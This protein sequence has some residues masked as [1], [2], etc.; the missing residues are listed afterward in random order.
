MVMTHLPSTVDRNPKLVWEM[1]L[2]G[3][4]RFA[5]GQPLHPNQTVTRREE[6][7]MGQS[8]R[9]AVFTCGDSRVPVELLFDVGLGDIFTI[10]TAGEVVDSAVLA[11]LEF[12]VEVLH[13]EVLVVLGHESCGAVGAATDV[14]LHGADVPTG[15]QR[16]IVEQIAPSIL[17]AKSKGKNTS[18]DFER[19]HSEAIRSKI[20][21]ISPII[22]ESVNTGETAFI[23]AHYSLADGS[24]DYFSV[25]GV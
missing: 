18:F 4:R 12:A 9:A 5:A 3:N 25:M 15:H 2:A 23:A 21:G 16:T 1:L 14:V 20:M 10:R 13:V 17:E 6:L 7:R 8:P 11:S 19:A 22:K 24:I